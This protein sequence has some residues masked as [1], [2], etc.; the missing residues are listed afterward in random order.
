MVCTTLC[1]EVV[2][3]GVVSKGTLHSRPCGKVGCSSAMRRRTWA[4]TA[5]AL[6]P[7][8]SWIVMP[9]AGWPLTA[10]PKP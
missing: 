2:M 10:K 8:A 9:A 7:L 3:K 1:T 4:A 6:A 5:S